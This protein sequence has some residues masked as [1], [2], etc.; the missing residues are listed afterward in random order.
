[1]RTISLSL[2]ISVAYCNSWLPN[3]WPHMAQPGNTY[4][5]N[6][7]LL[8]LKLFDCAQST[9]SV[10]QRWMWYAHDQKIWKEKETVRNSCGDAK[11]FCGESTTVENL[12]KISIS[13]F[14]ISVLFHSVQIS[15]VP[16]PASYAWGIA[17]FCPGRDSS[18]F[19]P[20]AVFI[21]SVASGSNLR[22]SIFLFYC[23]TLFGFTSHVA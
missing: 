18:H 5:K 9:L 14:G 12:S 10:I 20:F 15:S 21:V 4:N 17:G 3:T 11:N 6:R 16:K 2:L 8:I 7:R 22:A 1:M 13:I 23:D 19:S